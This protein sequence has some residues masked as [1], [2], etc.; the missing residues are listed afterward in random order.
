ML[1]EGGPRTTIPTPPS[2]S[3]MSVQDEEQ[4]K[5]LGEATEMAKNLAAHLRVQ[6]ELKKREM[7]LK[8]KEIAHLNLLKHIQILM[9]TA[10]SNVW[11]KIN[12]VGLWG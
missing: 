11:S 2:T 4:H 6:H 7:T 3:P 1:G 12:N 9:Q 10:I 5:Q 8:Q